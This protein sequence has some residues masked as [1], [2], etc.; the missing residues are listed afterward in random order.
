MRSTFGFHDES[1]NTRMGNFLSLLLTEYDLHPYTFLLVPVRELEAIGVYSDLSSFIN[2][3]NLLYGKLFGIPV[4]RDIDAEQYD[5]LRY[6]GR[7]PMPKRVLPDAHRLECKEG[8]LRALPEL[9]K[10]SLRRKMLQEFI[11]NNKFTSNNKYKLIAK[12]FRLFLYKNS[13]DTSI[14]ML[15]LKN[16]K[17]KGIMAVRNVQLTINKILIDTPLRLRVTKK[18]SYMEII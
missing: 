14:L 17:A 7:Q 3:A 12:I 10:T 11:S 1:N 9:L 16:R 5:P 6:T 2:K 15:L 4:I 8:F 13:I 18:I